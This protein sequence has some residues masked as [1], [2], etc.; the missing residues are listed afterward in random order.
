MTL[1]LTKVRFNS[2]RTLAFSAEEVLQNWRS[3]SAGY[4]GRAAPQSSK[5][6]SVL[7]VCLI[8][9]R[10]AKCC[11]PPTC[12]TLISCWSRVRA[13]T[14]LIVF[15]DDMDGLRKVPESVPNRGQMAAYIGQPVSRI[16]D[17]FGCCPS[18]AAHMIGMLADFLKPVAVDYELMRSSEAYASGLFRPRRCSSSW[19]T[20]RR[21]S[22]SSPR[23]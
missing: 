18:F 15:I 14:R 21:S 20:T 4:A 8:W 16:P 2:G 22:T 6:A 7:R 3:V 23:P 13:R 1:H 10:W 12:A 5:A 19:T 9:V 11:A 17:P